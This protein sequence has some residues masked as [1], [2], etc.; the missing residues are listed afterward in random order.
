VTARLQIDCITVDD[1]MDVYRRIVGVGGPNL[2]GI[3]APDISSIGAE[4]RRRGMA[5]RERPRWGLSSDEAIE[6][7]LAGKWTFY[8]Q[9]GIYDVVNVALGT[10]PTGRLY[11]KTDNDQDTPDEMLFLPRCW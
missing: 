5:V 1:T 6:G 3:P 4:L 2:P 7:M 9:L 11:L 10:S 8:V